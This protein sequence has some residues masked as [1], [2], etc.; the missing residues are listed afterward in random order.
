MSL[1]QIPTLTDGSTA[2]R[3][4]VRLEEQDWLF[5]FVWN[6]RVGQWGMSILSLEGAAVLT[7]Q[8]IVCGVSLLMRA[9]GGPPGQLVA[10]SEDASNLAPGLQELGGRVKLTYIT[11]DDELLA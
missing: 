11:S 8:A 7:G 5:D 9:Q 1:I 4:R 3:E 2:Y 10:Y 6:A